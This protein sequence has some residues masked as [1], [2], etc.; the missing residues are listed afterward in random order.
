MS[1][2]LEI[3]LPGPLLDSPPALVVETKFQFLS[4]FFSYTMVRTHTILEQIKERSA[5]SFYII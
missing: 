4:R 3:S 2:V 5:F 1:T